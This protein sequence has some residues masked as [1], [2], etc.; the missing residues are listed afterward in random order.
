M[1][2]RDFFK[3][4]A[5]ISVAG[6]V[7]SPVA[8]AEAPK[9]KNSIFP[10]IV[11]AGV[12]TRLCIDLADK[13]VLENEL[14]IKFI[15][16]NGLKM[17]GTRVDFY[18]F[19]VL[20]HEVIDGKIYIEHAFA[21]NQEHTF[22]VLKK[23]ETNRLNNFALLHIY[24]LEESL[25][26]LT[27]MK[28]EFHM[29]STTSDGKHSEADMLLSCY[30]QGYDFAALGD[31]KMLF[32]WFGR[33]A[34][35]PRN[36]RYGYE[37][38]LAE[39]IAAAPSSMAIFKAEEVHLDNGAHLHHFGGSEGIVEWVSN[40]AEEY[41]A[42]IERREAAFAGKFKIPTDAKCM[43]IA[44]FVFDKARE[45][46]GISVFNHPTWTIAKHHSLSDELARALFLSEKCD[47][48]EVANYSTENNMR[49]IAWIAESAPMRRRRHVF[50]GNSDAHDKK[51]VGGAYTI[52]FAKSTSLGDV[53]AA[54]LKGDCLAVDNHQKTKIILGRYELV[55]YAYFL[56]REYYPELKR[57]R[58][59][60][61]DALEGVF[62]GAANADFGKNF[63]DMVAR[64]KK[65]CKA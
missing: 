47:A 28:G 21:G 51:E 63:T 24:S 58:A 18:D 40:H 62:C 41:A 37:K 5:A 42:E 8:G 25:Y 60:E 10:K 53:K 30:R 11:R 20:P 34:G 32:E 7:N 17:D 23:G 4:A 55:E 26:A 64:H 9:K 65:A 44:D 61:A 2:R 6:A 16:R 56:E 39:I 38:R 49:A 15:P 14:E 43:A 50:V 19:D 52:V 57:I 22:W 1:N 59:A 12:K 13:S 29:H 3:A 33:P 35:D 46:G 45:F 36:V 48:C 31:H 54:I 27:P